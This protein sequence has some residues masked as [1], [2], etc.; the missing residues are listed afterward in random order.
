M[1]I[2]GSSI[3]WAWPIYECIKKGLYYKKP[4]IEMPNL[5][6][7]TSKYDTLKKKKNLGNQTF[8]IAFSIFM[9]PLKKC[10][11]VFFWSIFW[12]WYFRKDSL[13]YVTHISWRIAY[14]LINFILAFRIYFWIYCVFLISY[15]WQFS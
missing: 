14:H 9:K 1:W 8:S 13:S 10:I 6:K 12:K 2:L 5:L 7:A 3:F 15:S 4:H 11:W